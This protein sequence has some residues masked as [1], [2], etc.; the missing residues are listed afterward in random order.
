LL[1]RGGN[2]E[3]TGELKHHVDLWGRGR[4]GTEHW[5][6]S[7]PSGLPALFIGLTGIDEEFRQRTEFAEPAL[8]DARLTQ[9]ADALGPVLKQFGGTDAAFTNCYPLR[10][11]STWD[12]TAIQRQQEGIAKW[13]RAG[14]AF[15]S[16]PSVGRH[17]ADAATK[18]EIA[19]RDD[20]GGLSLLSAGLRQVTTATAKQLRLTN[21]LDHVQSQLIAVAERWLVKPDGQFERNQRLAC[22]RQVLDWLTAE[23]RQIHDRVAALKQALSIQEG[24]QTP[25]AAPSPDDEHSDGRFTS[26]DLYADALRAFLGHWAARTVTEKWSRLILATPP[27]GTWLPLDTIRSLSSYLRDYFCMPAVFEPLSQRLWSIVN[28]RFRDEGARR[29]A[30]QRYVRLVL[31]DV[32]LNPGLDAAAD[33]AEPNCPNAE[34][35]GSMASWVWRWQRRL[36]EALAAGAGAAL[37]IP[38]GNDELKQLLETLSVA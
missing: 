11:P 5:P 24:E 21:S 33:S 34:R 26:L 12:A 4:Y 7:V 35:F 29:E 25:L 16:S 14:Q 2:L 36:P 8:Y 38:P 23:P 3:V 32:I 18:W 31:N 20:D 10:Y 13:D 9:L 28:M 19:L 37:Q 15:L 30:R 22:A 17:V 1:V 27:R 6:Q